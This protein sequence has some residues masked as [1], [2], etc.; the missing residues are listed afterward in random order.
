MSQNAFDILKERGFIEQCTH[1]EELRELLGKERV[2]F[3]NGYDPT[4]DSLTAG[5]FLT[6]MALAH[7]QRA[8]HKPIVLMGS[9]TGMVGDPT[10]RTEMRRVMTRDEVDHNIACQKK[11][12][13]RFI[14]FD[15]DGAVLV[16]NGDWLLDLKYVEFMRDYG[17]HFNVN[18]MLSADTYKVRLESGLTFFEMNYMLMQAY[19]FLYLYRKYGC[20]LQVGGNDQWSNI[21]SGAELIRKVENAGAY[22]LTYK[23][24]TTADGRKMGKTAAGAVWLDATRTSPYEFFQYWRNTDDSTVIRD[25]KLLTFLPLEEINAMQN[26]EGSEL[27]RAKEILAYEIT[28]IAHGEEEADKALAA[29]K[30]IFAGGGSGAG[31]PRTEIA[32]E[33]LGE[34][35]NI[36][37]LLEKAKLIQTRSEGRRLIDQGGL[38]VNDIKVE[39]YEHTVKPGDFKDGSVIVQKG[40]KVFHK[41]ILM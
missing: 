32:A 13:E 27:N 41:V 34:G 29:S 37:L 28:K 20:L 6:L 3:Y 22:A 9:G 39:T 33:E 40:K 35:M 15:G 11:Q 23:L 25:L 16:K 17:V 36:V 18:K 26:W 19:D 8:G 2:T 21:I 14:N 5:H 12:F 31:M 38:K 4:A 7:L 1:E 24:L 10:D 30:A